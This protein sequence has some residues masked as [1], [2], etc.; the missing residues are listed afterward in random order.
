MKRYLIILLLFFLSLSSNVQAEPMVIQTLE[1]F[2]LDISHEYL[3]RGGRYQWRIQFTG[4][5]VFENKQQYLIST[6]LRAE[7]LSWWSK[8]NTKR[9]GCRFSFI[10]SRLQN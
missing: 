6:F 10:S 7:R 9:N 2:T 8:M 5:T 1:Y 4:T 3:L